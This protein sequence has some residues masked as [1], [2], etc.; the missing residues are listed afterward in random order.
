MERGRYI[1]PGDCLFVFV[2]MTNTIISPDTNIHSLNPLSNTKLADCRM[3]EVTSNVTTSNWTR[4]LGSSNNNFYFIFYI[5][6]VS[7]A[8]FYSLFIIFKY[9]KVTVFIHRLN[10]GLKPA[11][12]KIY[13]SVKCV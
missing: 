12:S 3:F 5:F 1:R 4:F 6:C 10:L 9:L 13:I 7:S 11:V 2:W 8:I